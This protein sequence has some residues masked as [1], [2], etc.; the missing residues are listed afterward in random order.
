MNTLHQTTGPNI[1]PG[2]PVSDSTTLRDAIRLLS[3]VK[4]D[5][6]KM[7]TIIGDLVTAGHFPMDAF[8]RIKKGYSRTILYREPAGFEVM[9]ARWSRNAITPVHGHPWFSLVYLIRGSLSESVFKMEKARLLE[10]EPKIYSTGEF[11]VD[12]G[13][14]GTFDNAIHQMTACEDSLS[15]H[16]YSD[17]AIKGE[18]YSI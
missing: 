7:V 10:I 6:V 5:D 3:R 1:H 16:I 17:D 12:R 14:E 15:L 8:P 4:Y 13:V 2:A 9:V 18:I 11:S